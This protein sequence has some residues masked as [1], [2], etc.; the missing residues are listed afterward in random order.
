MTNQYGRFQIIDDHK[1]GTVTLCVENVNR[2]ED[3]WLTLS[4][5][6]SRR[7]VGYLFFKRIGPHLFEVTEVRQADGPL[8]HPEAASS[9]DAA[10]QP[11]ETG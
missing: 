10:R 8:L 2:D 4:Y 3:H 5:G 9:H 7:P 11:G 1:N 6:G